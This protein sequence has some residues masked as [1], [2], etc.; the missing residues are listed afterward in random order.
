MKVAQPLC[1][2]E[3]PKVRHTGLPRWDSSQEAALQLAGM[4]AEW[5]FRQ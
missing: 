2:R 4:T 3:V 1:C 5:L